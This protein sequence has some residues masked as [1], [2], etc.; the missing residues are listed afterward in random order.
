MQ[1]MFKQCK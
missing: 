1:T